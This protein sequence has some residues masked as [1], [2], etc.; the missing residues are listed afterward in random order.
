MSVD[1]ALAHFSKEKQSYLDDLKALVRIP[2]VSFPGFDREH[3]RASADENPDLLWALRGAGGNFGVA[4]TL[5]FRLHPL[6]H[7]VG[8]H[9]STAAT[10]SAARCG[11]SATSCPT[12][13]AC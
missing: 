7:V 1:R 4:T 2:S 5:E 12:H 9:S 6:E 10:A 8:G 11:N 3:V 13:H